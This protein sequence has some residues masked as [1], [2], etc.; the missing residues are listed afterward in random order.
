MA[1]I[2]VAHEVRLIQEES[3]NNVNVSLSAFRALIRSIGS[4]I[5]KFRGRNRDVNYV[6]VLKCLD[7]CRFV[8]LSV[9]KGCFRVV[10]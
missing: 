6:N 5:S 10:G 4:R 3:L 7:F 9:P 1:D 2:E 8:W